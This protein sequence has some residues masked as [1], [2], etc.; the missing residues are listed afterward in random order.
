MRAPRRRG[1]DPYSDGVE[2]AAGVPAAFVPT[3]LPNLYGWWRADSGITVATGVSVWQDSVNA[4]QLVQA[5]T[6]KQPAFNA[7][8]ASMNN[9]P[10]VDFVAANLQCLVS[11]Q[12]AADWKFLTDGSGATVCCAFQAASSGTS[13]TIWRVGNG[14]PQANLTIS[15]T[16]RY[17]CN[18]DNCYS[19]NSFVPIT[20][21]AIH[22]MSVGSARSPQWDNTIQGVHAS[23]AFSGTPSASNPTTAMGIGGLQNGAGVSNCTI[24]ELIVY[25]QSFDDPDL[26][27]LYTYLSNR[28]GAL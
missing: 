19:L 27:Q 6:T 18:V 13:K 4:R 20:D 28:Y 14:A 1:Y 16:P 12:V 2:Q 10:G 3:D 26:A 24:C 22:V 8:V 9:E 7:A 23:G 15:D 21:P 17:T 5:T 25:D 11:S